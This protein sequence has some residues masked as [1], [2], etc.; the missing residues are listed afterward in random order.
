MT[1]SQSNI[2]TFGDVEEKDRRGQLFDLFKNCPIPADEIFLNLGLFLT[3]QTLSRI[4]FIDF[5]YRQILEVQGIV[6]EFGCRW[7][8]NLALFSALR[9]IYEPFNRLRKVVGF[10]TFEGF[11]KTSEKDG[12]K[13][14]PGMYSVTPAYDGYL[15]RLMDLQEKES[16][17]AHLRKHAIVKGD[18][19][20]RIKE[21]L[22][23][24]P[25]TVVALA[26]FDL[27]LFEPTRDCLL[28]IKDRLTPGSILGFDE[29]NDPV[30]PGETAAFKEV[31][32]FH[33]WGIRRYR[34]NSRTSYVVF[35]HS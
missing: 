12:N 10:D 8:Q 9:G 3:P 18:A 5:L 7:G 22:E 33:R 20:V 32:G 1:H 28:A 31:F 4:L 24:N 26:Y 6:I 15:Q 35:D 13:V 25:E 27:D 23:R 21:Y 19:T 30:T 2:L 29:L 16:P 17:L 11:F 34:Y 14:G